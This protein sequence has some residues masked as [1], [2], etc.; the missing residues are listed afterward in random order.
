M[1]TIGEKIRVFREQIDPKMPRAELGKKAFQK[2]SYSAADSK[3]S[4]IEN[5]K[6]EATI[7]ELQEIAKILRIRWQDFLSENLA[8]QAQERLTSF[9]PRPKF[10]KSQ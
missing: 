6:Q 5:G 8:L 3:L 10:N 9:Y 1:I 4:R 7:S 2:E